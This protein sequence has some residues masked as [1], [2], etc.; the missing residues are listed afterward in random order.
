ME[1]T[2][3]DKTVVS[4]LFIILVLIISGCANLESAK[5]KYIMRGQVLEVTGDTAYLCIGSE[6]GA[7]VGQEYTVY[8]FVKV[9]TVRT[10]STLNYVLKK[11][12]T[13]VIKIIEIVHE[14]MATAKILR[15]EVR[16]NDVVELNP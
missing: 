11:E 16:E 8:R 4:I 9:P 15:G 2:M 5:H 10:R 1:D 6:D 14:H 7:Q 13:G 12:Q 3:K